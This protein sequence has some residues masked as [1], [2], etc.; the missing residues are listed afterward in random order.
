MTAF[1]VFNELSAM[2]LAPDTASGQRNLDALSE[3]L[4]DTRIPGKRVLVTPPAF[5]QLQV[6]A[7]Y[8]VGRWIAEYKHRDPDRRLRIKTLLDRRKEFNEC[9]PDEHLESVDVEYRCAGEVVRGLCTAILADGLAISLLSTEEWNVPSVRIEKTWIEGEKVETRT[10]DVL[11]AGRAAHID[12][13]S[14]WLQRR[15]T[16]LP[17]NGTQLWEQRGALFPSLD[18]CTCVEDQIQGLGGDG[19]PFRAAM[20]GLRDLQSYCES[21]TAGPFDI[22]GLNNASGESPTTLEKFREERT[23]R[24][25][26][27]QDRVFEWHVKR[28]DTRV[29]FFDFPAQKRLLVG[30]VGSHLRT[31]K[32]Q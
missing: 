19:P 5:L 13:H 32:Y 4:V 10:L 22:H 25:P 14:S 20:R 26:D 8:S 9:I 3:I 6:S 1:L 28:G 18:F 24:C 16:P 31:A 29:H 7:G 23:F 11:H 30:Y 12:E 2:Q 15:Q 27:G 21:W 17:T